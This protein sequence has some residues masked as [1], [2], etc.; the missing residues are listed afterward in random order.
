MG[1]ISKLGTGLL[2]TAALGFSVQYYMYHGQLMDASCYNQNPSPGEKVWVK[3][4][5]TAST[6]SFAIHTSGKVRILN[7]AGNTKAETAFKE[8]DLKRDKNGDM[9]VAINGHRHGNVIDVESIR[10]RNSEVSV[11]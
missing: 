7:E 4:A 3:C 9:P 6:T 10:A 11:H 1:T 2:M 5:P 8:G